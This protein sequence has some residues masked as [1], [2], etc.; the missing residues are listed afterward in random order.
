[1]NNSLPNDK[2]LDMTKSKAFAD[3]KL[4]ITKITISSFD[5]IENT[6][7]KG[8][9]AGYQHFL[10]FPTVFSKAFILRVVILW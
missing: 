3:N 9:N 8:R 1:M 4:N 6:V 2:T 10:P 5:S 7:G